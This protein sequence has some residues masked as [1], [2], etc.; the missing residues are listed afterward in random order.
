MVRLVGCASFSRGCVVD[1]EV[2]GACYVV[3]LEGDVLTEMVGSVCDVEVGCECAGLL[4]DAV[5]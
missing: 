4:R 1:C 5:I 3:C 2:C